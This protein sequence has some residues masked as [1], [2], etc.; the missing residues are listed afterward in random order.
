MQDERISMTQKEINRT[1]VIKQI[2]DRKT[3]QIEAAKILNLGDRQ[4]RRIYKRYKEEGAKGMVSRHKGGNRK[5][6]LEFKENTIEIIR[7]NYADF[8]PTFAAE[9][10]EE[11]DDIKINR[12][13]IRQWMK[14]AGLWKG[15]R[16]KKA[17]I[18]Q[19]R[20][21]RPCK[22]E[23]VQIDGSPHDWFEVYR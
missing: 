1:V 15:K 19:S 11:L 18:H 6:S 9:K 3:T 2:S 10:L 13:T 23:L 21:R 14:E 17:R 12:E 5:Y 7:T 22:G 20:E 8:K 16:R 4:I